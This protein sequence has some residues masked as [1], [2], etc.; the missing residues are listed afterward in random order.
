MA[1]AS[2][3]G[4]KD[5]ESGSG[6]TVPAA[7]AEIGRRLRRKHAAPHI[8]ERRSAAMCNVGEWTLPASTR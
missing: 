2:D 6:R 5:S 1:S 3:S 7:A 8:G 4:A